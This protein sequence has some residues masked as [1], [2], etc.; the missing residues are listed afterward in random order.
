MVENKRMLTPSTAFDGC[1]QQH[2]L[3]T[4]N[5]RWIDD[6]KKTAKIAA[7]SCE[8]GNDFFSSNAHCRSR[9]IAMQ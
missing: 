9:I 5:D 8:T 1:M 3:T 4:N 7:S 2:R 6:K